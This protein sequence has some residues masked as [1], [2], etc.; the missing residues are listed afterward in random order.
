VVDLGSAGVRCIAAALSLLIPNRGEALARG[1][2]AASRRPIVF[3]AL[4]I[5]PALAFVPLAFGLWCAL[6][7]SSLV[8]FSLRLAGLFIISCHLAY[9]LIGAGGLERG[10]PRAGGRAGSTLV[11]AA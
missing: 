9:F 8:P 7:R 4:A 6:H 5:S 3:L 11:P 2:S 1:L 10:A